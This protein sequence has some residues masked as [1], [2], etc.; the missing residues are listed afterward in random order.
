[1]TDNNMKAFLSAQKGEINAVLMYKE[2]AKITKDEE[3]KNIFLQA[4]ADEGKHANILKKQ[5]NQ[6]VKPSKVQAKVLGCLYRVF[7]K[8]IMFSIISKGETSGGN[9]Y[10]PY[11]SDYPE[12]EEMMNDEYHHAKIFS[13][14]SK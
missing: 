12:F 8:K 2:F 14:L 5:T 7:P 10:E 4:A 1:M 13:D 3:L 11:I 6:T 9:G